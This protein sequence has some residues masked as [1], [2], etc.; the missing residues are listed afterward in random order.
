MTGLS[1]LVV[2]MVVFIAYLFIPRRPSRA[3]K[4]WISTFLVLDLVSGFIAVFEYRGQSAGHT[5]VDKSGTNRVYGDLDPSVE[6]PTGMSVAERV[7]ALGGPERVQFTLWSQESQRSASKRLEW[8][9]FLALLAF[10]LVLVLPAL[11]LSKIALPPQNA[12]SVGA[13][14]TPP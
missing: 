11:L 6:N 3:W 1:T 14:R 12:R 13:K 10:A 9:Y 4:V 8:S 7:A 2:L 5:Y